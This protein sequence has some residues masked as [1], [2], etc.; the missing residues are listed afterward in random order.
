MKCQGAA[1]CLPRVRHYCWP[2]VLFPRLFRGHQKQPIAVSTTVV[3]WHQLFSLCL[4][5]ALLK[6]ETSSPKKRFPF[7]G[8]HAPATC[9]AVTVEAPCV[10]RVPVFF[11]RV[12]DQLSPGRPPV[13]WTSGSE[14]R[15]ATTRAPRFWF[16]GGRRVLRVQWFPWGG[17]FLRG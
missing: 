8:R 9:A 2:L 11:S 5:A 10:K 16:E 12:T 6:M 3:Q 14:G 13:A 15:K 1:W 17:G 7:L 4:V